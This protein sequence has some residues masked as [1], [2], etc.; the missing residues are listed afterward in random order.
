M[1]YVNI[2]VAVPIFVLFLDANQAEAIGIRELMMKRW[3]VSE[4]ADI[5]RKVL[6]NKKE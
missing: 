4:M 1:G 3:E 5:I 6:E 2:I